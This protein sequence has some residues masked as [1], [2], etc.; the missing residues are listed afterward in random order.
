VIGGFEVHGFWSALLCRVEKLQCKRG[1]IW[2][3]GAGEFAG[4]VLIT[5]LQMKNPLKAML[6]EGPIIKTLASVTFSVVGGTG[7]EPATSTV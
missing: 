1:F 5:S 7:F 2:R 3:K 4:A 6:S